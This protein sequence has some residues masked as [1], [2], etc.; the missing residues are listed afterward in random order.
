[1]GL[2]RFKPAQ[3]QDYETALA[4]SQKQPQ[5]G[6]LDNEMNIYAIDLGNSADEASWWFC[7]H[8]L[9]RAFHSK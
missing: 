8:L 9:G 7:R 2:E 6:P 1:M 5:A 4:E 3:E